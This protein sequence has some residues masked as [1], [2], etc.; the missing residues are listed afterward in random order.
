MSVE[1]VIFDLGGVILDS[2][3]DAIAAF[4]Q[5]HSIRA[6]TINRHVFV[7]GSGGAWARHERGEFGP[8][9]FLA[10]FRAEFESAGLDVDTAELM[11][12]VDASIRVRPEMV[13]AVDRLRRRGVKAAALTNN[14][15]PFGPDGLAAHFDVVVESVVE[16]TRKPERR[17]YEICIER[18]G[19]EPGGCVMLDDLGPNLKPAKAMGMKTVKVT[20][21][22][23]A[24]AELDAIFGQL[25][26]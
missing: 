5:R 12:D 8:E 2:P 20:S 6:G 18:L 11:L 19:V 3:L 13:R 7:S 21:A 24:L 26:S 10:A 9:E 25:K 23:Q 15:I 16:G 1:A 4:E 22:A 17:I 14:W